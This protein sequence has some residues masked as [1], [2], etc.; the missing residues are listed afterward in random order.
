MRILIIED[1]KE[2][3]S[4]L[5]DGFEQ[6][7]FA[8]DIALDGKNGLFLATTNEYD[9]VILDLSLPK[10]DGKKV[11]RQ[12]RSEGYQY[13]ILILTVKSEIDIKVDMLQIGADDYMTK[14]F[15]FEELLART[16][17]LIKRPERRS[18]DILEIDDLV[19]DNRKRR[20]TRG[21]KKISLTKKEYSILE[22]LLKNVDA[23]K[24]KTEIID[25][26]WDREANPFSNTIETHISHLRGK[27][28]KGAKRKLIHTSNG[29]GYS[30]GLDLQK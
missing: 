12:I 24:S 18:K 16:K 2:I 6:A 20:V 25:N 8:T 9:V 5:R 3:S 30:V 1:E 7:G 23:V 14:P 19:L 13:P 11:C 27:I 15:A 17:A 10:L 29:I 22:Y 4:F 21:N 26:V 28:D